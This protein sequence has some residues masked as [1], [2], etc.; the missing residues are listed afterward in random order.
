MPGCC[1]LLSDCLFG[2]FLI[3]NL[4]VLG[5]FGHEGARAESARRFEELSTKQDERRGING[6]SGCL[7]ECAPC[8][9]G[10]G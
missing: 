7:G 6:D 1:S 9:R 8:E 5:S 10:G 4:I 3:A 2:A